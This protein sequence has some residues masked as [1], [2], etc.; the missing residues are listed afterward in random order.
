VRYRTNGLRQ[1]NTVSKM[2][3]NRCFFSAKM[4]RGLRLHDAKRTTAIIFAL[5]ALC[6]TTVLPIVSA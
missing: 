2:R 6:E 1:L 4:S 5:W 3:Q